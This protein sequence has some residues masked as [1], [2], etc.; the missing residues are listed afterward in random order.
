MGVAFSG[1]SMRRPPRV[2]N[3][4]VTLERLFVEPHLEIAELTFGASTIKM[5]VLER[6]D[7]GAVVAAV[8]ETAQRVDQVNRDRL[9]G[10]NSDDATH[11]S[12]P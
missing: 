12:C 11:G 3:P 8:L 6:G 7:A 5:S 2:A 10:E 9:I 1:A 4:D